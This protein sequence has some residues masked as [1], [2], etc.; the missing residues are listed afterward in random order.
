M[1]RSALRITSSCACA[2][3]VLASTTTASSSCFSS[4]TIGCCCSATPS[5]WIVPRRWLARVTSIMLSPHTTHSHMPYLVVTAP[6]ACG[7]GGV[8]SIAIW[9]ST[10]S[11]PL[12]SHRRRAT[13][14][15][16]RENSS[17]GVLWIVLV[18]LVGRGVGA[19]VVVDRGR[20][21][22]TAGSQEGGAV[23]CRSG[24]ATHSHS[25]S[26]QIAGLETFNRHHQARG[27]GISFLASG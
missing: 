17:E 9:I 16:P 24:T 19:V 14:F 1:P 23:E 13:T 10:I 6:R 27:G 20:G 5:A 8:W 22:L 7:G 2:R 21:V 26:L 11:I 12:H 18:R 4:S 15:L 25:W 3:A